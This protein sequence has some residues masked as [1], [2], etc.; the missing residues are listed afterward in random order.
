MNKVTTKEAKTRRRQERKQMLAVLSA[1]YPVFD[2]EKP[3]P[4]AIGSQA[5]IMEALPDA[6]RKSVQRFLRFWTK[7]KAYLQAIQADD[8]VR[9]N[10][11]GSVAGP[12]AEQHREHSVRVS[13]K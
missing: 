5:Q 6:S 11:D 13:Q 2:L 4:L 10:L 7:R 3:K 12:V 9:Y 8:A 1:F